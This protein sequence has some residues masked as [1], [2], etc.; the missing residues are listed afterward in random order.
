MLYRQGHTPRTDAARRVL[1]SLEP[2]TMRRSPARA[3]RR[4]LA[5][6]LLLLAAAGGF[7]AGVASERAHLLPGSIWH[8]PPELAATFSIFWEA[9]SLVREHY[10]DQSA[11]DPRRMTYGAV[12]GML[13]SLGDEGHTRFLSPEDLQAFQES[14]AGR[15]EGIGAEIAVRDGRPT[16]VAPLPGSPAQQAGLRAGDIL[17][18]V[19][20]Q[21]VSD[22]SIDQ[23]VSRVRGPAGTS[24]TLTV[25]HRGEA[26]LTDI[27][28]VRAQIIVPNVSWAILPG[29]GVAHVAVSQFGERASDDLV[30]ALQE[31]RAGGARGVILDLRNNPGGLRNEAVEVASQFLADGNVLLEQDAQGRRTPLPVKAGGVA[32]D[33]PLAVL[34]NEGT[35][36]AAEIVAGALQDHQ[37]GPL[38][39]TTTFGTGT[40]LS[41][42]SLSDGSAVLLGTVEWLTPN[43]RRIWHQGITPDV[44]VTLPANAIPLTPREESGLTM[45]EIRARQDTQL[46]RALDDVLP[47]LPAASD[48]GTACC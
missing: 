21:D 5:T 27:T 46:L 17:V 38:I 44:R 26:S 47:R 1:G 13:R 15:L 31:A 43:G 30:A 41:T 29:T 25:L 3:A 10:V 23:I 20:G 45:E 8:E 19:D 33:M 39:G 35:Q 16:I 42:F 37:R 6:L 40:V 18:R 48:R 22:L 11:V 4:A 24:V 32:V 12:E 36:S 7:A 14:L 28:V 9:W 34:I 2:D